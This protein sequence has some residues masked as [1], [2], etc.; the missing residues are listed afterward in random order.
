MAEDLLCHFYETK[1]VVDLRPPHTREEPK[2]TATERI[3]LWTTFRGV[4]DLIKKLPDEGGAEDATSAI[5]S[6]PARDAYLTWEIISFLLCCLS[7]PDLRDIL[8]LQSGTEDFYDRVGGKAGI[9]PLLSSCGDRLRRLAEDPNSTY[10]GH[11]LPP[12]TPLGYFGIFDH[13][14]EEYMEQFD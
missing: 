14:Q 8:R 6:L 10:R 5:G 11:S 13:W 4:W 7:K 2:L 3:R 12:K 1:V 9:V